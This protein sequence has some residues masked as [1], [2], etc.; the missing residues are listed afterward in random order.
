[1]LNL[2]LLVLLQFWVV[3]DAKDSN[4]VAERLEDQIRDETTLSFLNGS[5]QG[6]GARHSSACFGSSSCS[7]SS[8]NATRRMSQTKVL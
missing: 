7:L 5:N 8:L 2:F 6:Q 1:M 4:A 3:G